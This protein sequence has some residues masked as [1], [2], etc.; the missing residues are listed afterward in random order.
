RI[1][2]SSIRPSWRRS[3]GS[4]LRRSAGVLT[5]SSNGDFDGDWD[6]DFLRISILRPDVTATQ[7]LCSS[8]GP[9]RFARRP[10][11]PVGLGM[12][13]LELAPAL[14]AGP[15]PWRSPTLTVGHR[16]VGCK[17]Q[18]NME[19]SRCILYYRKRDAIPD[20]RVSRLTTNRF[21]RFI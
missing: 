10:A 17:R 9:Q 13:P 21:R 7:A 15:D 4:N 11:T 5:L 16:T 3:D 12:P 20:L 2:A 1:C 19:G 8:D 14:L 18:G 6:N